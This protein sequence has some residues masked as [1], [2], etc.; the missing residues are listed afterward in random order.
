[1]L[2][3]KRVAHARLDPEARQRE[4]AQ[5]RAEIEAIVREVASQTAIPVFQQPEICGHGAMNY[6]LGLG[7][8]ARI[9]AA[10]DGTFTLYNELE[11]RS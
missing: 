1:M 10:Q 5:D 7:A 8:M 3:I 2:P 9:R 4:Q 11:V 6:P